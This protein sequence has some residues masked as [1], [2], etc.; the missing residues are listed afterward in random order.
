VD[1]TVHE[2]ACPYKHRLE[3]YGPASL[4]KPGNISTVTGLET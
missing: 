1:H 3:A 2:H 4:K